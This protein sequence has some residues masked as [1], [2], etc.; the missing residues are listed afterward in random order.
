[1]TAISSLLSK[2]EQSDV[3]GIEQIMKTLVPEYTPE[4]N[5]IDVK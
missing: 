3:V 2:C 4:N 1:M 5:V